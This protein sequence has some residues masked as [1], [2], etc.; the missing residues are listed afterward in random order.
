MNPDRFVKVFDIVDA[1]FPSWTF[2]ALGPFFLVVSVM[3]SFFPSVVR[4]IGIPYLDVQPWLQRVLRFAV[5]IFA[6]VW[7]V[8]VFWA[9]YPEYLRYKSLAEEN[10]CRVVEGPVEHFVPMPYGG[11]TPESFSVAGVQFR[12][13]EF[14]ITNAFNHASSHGGPVDAGSYVRICYEP[15]QNA[16]LRLEVRDFQGEVKYKRRLFG[17]P[18]TVDTR[19]IVHETP[20][21]AE[22]YGYFVLIFLLPILDHLA[23]R[24]MFLPFLR[25][26]LRFGSVPVQDIVV[27]ATLQAGTNI[28]LRNSMVYWDREHR[29]IWLRPRGFNLIQMPLTIARLNLTADGRSIRGFEIC[30]SPTALFGSALFLWAAYHLLS[31]APVANGPRW[32][33]IVFLGVVVVIGGWINLR[34]LRSR[35]EKLVGD[36]VADLSARS[37][38]VPSARA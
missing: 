8:V 21:A 34:V 25:R 10:R 27:L 2:L 12:Y 16:I 5:P 33:M 1:G 31:A 37:M 7:T 29:L 15:L 23:I 14:R 24:S 18:G 4:A 6:L 20:G 17:F 13:S 30:L 35:M 26:F 3:A 11:K 22:A 38:P 9:T 32:A 36:A 19:K 28:K